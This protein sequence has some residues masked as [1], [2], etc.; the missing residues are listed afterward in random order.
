[1]SPTQKIYANPDGIQI[2]RKKNY[3]IM[4]RENNI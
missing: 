3:Q 1:M 4:Y 2:K